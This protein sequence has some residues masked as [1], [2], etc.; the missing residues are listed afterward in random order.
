MSIHAS[1][2]A[3]R[4]DAVDLLR[5]AWRVE[6][7]TSCDCRIQATCVQIR[8][9]GSSFG[10]DLHHQSD[11]SLDRHAAYPIVGLGACPFYVIL[12][13]EPAVEEHQSGMAMPMLSSLASSPWGS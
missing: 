1:T 8:G 3:V 7:S 12:T 9:L 4:T 6:L 11:V 5:I 13:E 10:F 2:R